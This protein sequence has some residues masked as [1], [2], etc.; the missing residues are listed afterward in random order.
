MKV[1]TKTG[2]KGETGLVGGTRISKS[3][4]RLETYGEVDELNSFIGAI[5]SALKYEKVSISGSE[6]LEFVQNVLFNLGSKL[7]CE[8]HSWETFKLPDVNAEDIN[9]L[10]NSMDEFDKELEPLK[11]FILPNGS[12]AASSCHIA[13]S[14]CRRAERRLVQFSK[15]HPTETPEN[16]IQFLNRLSDYLFIYSRYINLKLGEKETIWKP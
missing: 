2:D 12:M 13:R 4:L 6:T 5:H 8:S 1:Y 7:A 16:S 11:N 15:A 14:V 10:E 9:R 3:D